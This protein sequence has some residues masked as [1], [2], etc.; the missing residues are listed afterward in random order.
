MEEAKK[1]ANGCGKIIEVLN[2]QAIYIDVN[3]TIYI[4]TD[5][6]LYT[7]YTGIQRNFKNIIFLIST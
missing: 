4:S 3:I 6:N 5:K 1:G 2:L 7:Q